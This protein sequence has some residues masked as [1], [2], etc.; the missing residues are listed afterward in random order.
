MVLT[1]VGF[2][3][4]PFVI[5]HVGTRDFGLWGIS[6]LFGV[7]GGLAVAEF[8]LNAAVVRYLAKHF[9]G[10]NQD[11][12][13]KTLVSGF[14]AFSAIGVF[15]SLILV[16][17]VSFEGIALFDKLIANEQTL[18]NQMVLLSALNFL[19][20]FPF[21]AIKSH[22]M[23]TKNFKHAEI[24]EIFRALIY[25]VLVVVFLSMGHGIVA[26]AVAETVSLVLAGLVFT[27]LPYYSAQQYFSLN[28]RY[29]RKSCL[30]EMSGLSLFA[31]WSRCAGLLATQAPGFIVAKILP[32]EFTAYFNIVRKF[33]QLV[34]QVQ[35]V[36]NGSIMP[37]IMGLKLEGRL[38]E[39][40]AMLLDFTRYSNFIVLLLFGGIFLGAEPILHLWLG[41]E[42]AW[43]ALL[44]RCFLVLF[45]LQNFFPLGFSA[46]T[47]T[48]HYRMF[49]PVNFLQN[50]ITLLLMTLL[51]S[52]FE[53]YGVALGILLSAC[54]FVPILNMRLLEM[55]GIGV[56]EFFEDVIQ[57]GL[58][59]PLVVVGL[60][61]YPVQLLYSHFQFIGFA[62]GEILF[63]VIYVVV[64]FSYGLTSQERH[65]IWQ[66]LPFFNSES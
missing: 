34:K 40:K 23:G 41:P 48:S 60:F 28:P 65:F 58:A 11:S 59:L 6:Q 18:V 26:V 37:Y 17:F 9:S 20:F 5:T 8:G 36:F 1:L 43:L 10:S 38:D 12:Y 29:F 49:V 21:L 45:V 39:A 47:E 19:F 56:R 25:L 27:L 63:A 57:R 62:A 14:L 4:V 2:I 66:K 52:R 7:R 33:P 31:F 44:M 35:G 46:M 51:M 55:H 24:W 15:A 42:F 54:I 53:L 32:P 30:V 16:F 22:Y 64:F 50:M 3:L 13:R 61:Y